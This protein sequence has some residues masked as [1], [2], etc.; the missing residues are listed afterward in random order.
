MQGRLAFLLSSNFLFRSSALCL[1]TLLDQSSQVLVE[2]LEARVPSPDDTYGLVLAPLLGVLVG[3]PQCLTYSDL[4][5]A[6][7][8]SWGT[9]GVKPRGP[10]TAPRGPAPSTPSR[11]TP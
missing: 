10:T 3:D 11:P 2:A 1:V 4:P 7:K 6:R 8:S 9:V 5:P